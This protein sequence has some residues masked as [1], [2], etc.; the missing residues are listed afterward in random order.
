MSWSSP[1]PMSWSSPP[2]ISPELELITSFRG[3]FVTWSVTVDPDDWRWL[4]VGLG[5]SR[6]PEDRENDGA[7][8]D[9]RA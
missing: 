4:P 8:L 1:P 3:P 6:C 2:P 9:L 5:V 7:L